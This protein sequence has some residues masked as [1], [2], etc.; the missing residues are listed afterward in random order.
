MKGKVWLVVSVFL[1]AALTLGVV[2]CD[3]EEDVDPDAPDEIVDE[4]VGFAEIQGI[5]P[6]AGIME[7]TDEAIDVYGLNLDVLEASD[8]AMTAELSMSIEN[9]EWIVVTG[10]APHWKFADWDLKFLE[11]PEEV[12]G[13]EEYIASMAHLGLADDMPEVHALLENFEWGDDEIGTVM[14]MNADVD[15]PMGNA[16]TWIADN[17]DIVDAWLPEDFGAEAD[18]QEVRIS[19][20]EWDCA[21]ASTYVIAAVLEDGGYSVDI[22]PVDA[23]VMWSGTA[24][25]DF[26]FFTTAWLP[27]THETYFAD[28]G[29]DLEEVGVSYEGARIGLVVPE[30]VTI[31][32]ITEINDYI[33]D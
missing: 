30:Y 16:Q 15:D 12:Y 25:G 9:N 6:G 21:T 31:D 29:D 13:G 2:G 20:V 26:D 4:D 33:I 27:G 3:V 23:A 10:W 28:Y 8:A 22:T 18:G 17:Q 19:M 7:A 32:S 24:T 5:E 14:D 1:V 11:D